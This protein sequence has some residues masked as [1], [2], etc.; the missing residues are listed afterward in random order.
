MGENESFNTD[1]YYLVLLSFT[2]MTFNYSALWYCKIDLFFKCNVIHIN[3]CQIDELIATPS[4]PRAKSEGSIIM[5]RHTM[6]INVC[7]S[8]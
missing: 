7:L 4:N 3:Y 8:D 6:S 1:F 2:C 5:K